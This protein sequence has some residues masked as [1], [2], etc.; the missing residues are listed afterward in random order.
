VTRTVDGA[1]AYARQ[2][3]AHVSMPASLRVQGFH[4]W[5]GACQGFVR[6]AYDIGA[7]FGSAWAQ[8]NGADPE[9]RH[10]GGSPDDAP[11]GAAL[12]FKGSGVNGHIDLAAK[13]FKSGRTAAW[14]NDLVRNGQIDKVPRT[15]PVGAWG[16]RYLGWLSAVND[17]DLPL[18]HG[19]K[20]KPK[21]TKRYV[22]VE[23]AMRNLE[24]SLRTAK[25]QHDTADVTALE[26][27]VE[28]LHG[29][30]TKLRHA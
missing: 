7:L 19:G 13:H 28:R 26:R 6:S 18:S 11:L 24:A 30:Y 4:D 27:E 14:S 8:W 29:L 17:V 5:E 3:H 9:D 2:Q 10:V 21:Q 20:A 16:Q 1:L 23:S 25:A 12:C 15:A 22:A